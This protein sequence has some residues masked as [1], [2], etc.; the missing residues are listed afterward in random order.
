MNFIIAEF[1]SQFSLDVHNNA[2]KYIS[3]FSAFLIGPSLFTLAVC[4]SFLRSRDE[5]CTRENKPILSTCP[6]WTFQN[7]V[8]R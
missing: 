5:I 2:L 8:D 3:D 6:L 7:E 4:L 1:M